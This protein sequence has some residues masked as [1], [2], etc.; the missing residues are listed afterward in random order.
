MPV[1]YG[2]ILLQ[3]IQLWLHPVHTL[4]TIDVG[5]EEIR[6]HNP[7]FYDLHHYYAEE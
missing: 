7:V 3:L 6:T 4:N 5:L 1:L 2:F